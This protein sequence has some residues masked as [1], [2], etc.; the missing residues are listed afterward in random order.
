MHQ[1][2]LPT[3]ILQ[4]SREGNLRAGKETH[5]DGRWLLE[6][7]KLVTWAAVPKPTGARRLPGRCRGSLMPPLTGCCPL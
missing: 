6:Y 2:R 4:L 7:E 1:F 5:A 3:E